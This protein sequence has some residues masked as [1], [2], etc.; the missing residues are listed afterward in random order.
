MGTHWE[1]WWACDLAVR[2]GRLT[3]G[4]VGELADALITSGTRARTSMP[5][6]ETT[7]KTASPSFACTAASR[8]AFFLPNLSSKRSSSALLSLYW[9]I[10]DLK[11]GRRFLSL[12]SACLEAGAAPNNPAAAGVAEAAP[13]LKADEGAAGA[14]AKATKKYI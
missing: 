1:G 7:R 13:K 2:A 11:Q 6:S 4:Y 14:A 3:V 10:A 9:G 5:C 8:R 12:N